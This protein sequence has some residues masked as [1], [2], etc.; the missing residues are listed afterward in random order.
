M[1]ADQHLPKGRSDDERGIS[2]RQF[3][4][5]GTVMGLG[6]TGVSVISACGSSA[7]SAERGNGSKAKNNPKR[8]VGQTTGDGRKVGKGQAIAK[9]S[10][11]GTNAALPFRDSE[12]GQPAVLVRLHNGDFVAYSA[13]CSHQGCT[14]A[15]KKQSRKLACPCHGAVFDPANDA[16][17]ESGPAPSPLQEIEVEVKDGEVIR[18]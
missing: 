4:R 7:K 15:Y 12:T 17:V 5:L 6:A 10:E 14:V 3:I 2:R 11:V 16:A 9:E 8:P 13:V 1:S 18:V